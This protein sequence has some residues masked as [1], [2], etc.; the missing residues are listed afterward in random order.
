MLPTDLPAQGIRTGHVIK[1]QQSV[2]NRPGWSLEVAY[3]HRERFVSPE[4][5]VSEVIR[6]SGWEHSYGRNTGLWRERVGGQP[7]TA[8]VYVVD[9]LRMVDGQPIC[10]LTYQWI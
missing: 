2:T 6:F 9:D 1:T 10:C 7:L 3:T 8:T 5:T 4:G